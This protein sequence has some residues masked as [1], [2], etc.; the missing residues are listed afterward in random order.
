MV[1]RSTLGVHPSFPNCMH[2][3]LRGAEKEDM[4]ED[5]AKQAPELPAW[6]RKRS[7]GGVLSLFI[8][9]I[10]RLCDHGELSQSAHA[11]TFLKLGVTI[12]LTDSKGRRKEKDFEKKKNPKKTKN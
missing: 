7:E 1:D 4:F 8:P 10:N 2:L 6:K 11:A 9:Q 12:F 5:T 3:Q